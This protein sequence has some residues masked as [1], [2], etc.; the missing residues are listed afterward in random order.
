M[1]RCSVWRAMSLGH[2]ELRSAAVGPQASA[3]ALR[4]RAE[5]GTGPPSTEGVGSTG[6]RRR[7]TYFGVGSG[8]KSVQNSFFQAGRICKLL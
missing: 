5:V 3:M 7:A 8:S 4:Q 2:L 6:A 1:S